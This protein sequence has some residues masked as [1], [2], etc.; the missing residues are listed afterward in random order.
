[1]GLPPLHGVQQ[2]VQIMG[3]PEVITGEAD[4]LHPVA[5]VPL[6]EVPD[7]ELAA[8]PPGPAIE[9]LWEDEEPVHPSHALAPEHDALQA[10]MRE[11]ERILL[12][13]VTMYSRHPFVGAIVHEWR[14]PGEIEPSGDANVDLLN[15]IHHYP[16][17][18]LQQ[19]RALFQ[20]LDDAIAL[21]TSL[22][23][24]DLQTITADQ[25]MEVF[26]KAVTA[27]QVLVLANLRLVVSTVKKY[28]DLS[29]LELS[30]LVQE[31]SIGLAKGIRRLVPR[32]GYRL[33]TVATSW[34]RQGATREMYEHGHVLGLPV[35]LQSGINSFRWH[36]QHL[37][38]REGNPPGDEE[39]AQA[40]G[41]G[42]DEIAKLR[43]L[44][45]RVVLSLNTPSDPERP[46]KGEC[47]DY[48]PGGVNPQDLTDQISDRQW[49]QER[50]LRNEPALTTRELTVVGL[51]FGLYDGTPWTQVD[52]GKKLGVSRMT[53]WKAEVSAMKKLRTGR[54]S[55]Y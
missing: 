22:G 2:Y 28:A 10:E 35:N 47:A 37:A 39:V 15:E 34:I 19:E 8:T 5:N 11:R 9:L 50:L 26:V 13:L 27:H 40:M 36:Y 52:I 48:L 20:L 43:Q 21:Y 41:R 1:M 14:T 42:P 23:N 3:V 44:A 54:G 53:V 29:D 4:Y 33:S 30:D 17:L 18:S 25:E 32:L 51:R 31:G 24:P 49:L 45:G 12:G 7:R 55:P 16:R 46:D 6:E 38:Q